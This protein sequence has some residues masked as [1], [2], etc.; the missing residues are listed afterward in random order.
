MKT[1]FARLNFNHPRLV[2]ALSIVLTIVL[3]SGIRNI[4]IEENVTEM[5]PKHLPLRKA[6][7]E[8]EDIFGG[9]D[10]IMVTIGNE[11]KINKNN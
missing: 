3:A 11:I 8:L 4:K 7:N 2:I 1:Q 6:L 10:V 5:I 9:S